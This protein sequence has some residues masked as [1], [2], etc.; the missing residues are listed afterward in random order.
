MDIM[1]KTVLDRESGLSAHYGVHLGG[2]RIRRIQSV[3]W[4][5]R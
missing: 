4:I 1:T 3:V 2:R 5:R